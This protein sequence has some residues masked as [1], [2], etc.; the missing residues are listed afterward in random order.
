MAVNWRER[1]EAGVDAQ[2]GVLKDSISPAVLFLKR[3]L[4]PPAYSHAL[5]ILA[6]FSGSIIQLIRLKIL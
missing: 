1:K 4:K 2:E 6:K 5:F 3:S